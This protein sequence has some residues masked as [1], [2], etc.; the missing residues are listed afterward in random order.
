MTYLLDTNIISFLVRE[1]QGEVAARASQLPNEDVVTSVIVAAEIAFGFAKRPA[2]KLQ[3]QTAEVL[4][5]IRIVAFDVTAITAYAA[6]R[7]DLETR[8]KPI[9]A[10]DTLIAAHALALDA[11]LVTAN[12]RESR[13]VAGL[14]VENWIV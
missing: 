11:T 5:R 3:R 14:R 2:P 12:E 4:D 6:I 9:G 10:N 1:P 13:C 7:A 8:G